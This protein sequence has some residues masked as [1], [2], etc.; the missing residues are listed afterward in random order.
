[1]R[2]LVILLLSVMTVFGAEDQWSRVSKLKS[3]VELRVYKRG[4]LQPVLAKM[5]ETTDENLVVIVKNEQVAIAKDDIDRIE[6]RPDQPGGR[7]VQETKTTASKTDPTSTSQSSSLVVRSRPD[8]ETI[9]RRPPA[10]PKK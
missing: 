6:Y 3:G 2:K 9:D 8:F 7:M 5:G 10:A 4:V 1:M